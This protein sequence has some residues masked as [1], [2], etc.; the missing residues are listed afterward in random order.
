M[1]SGYH[2]YITIILGCL[3]HVLIVLG[4]CITK[5]LNDGPVGWTAAFAYFERYKLGHEKKKTQNCFTGGWTCQVG[6]VGQAIFKNIFYFL[7]LVAKMTLKTQKFWKKLTFFAEKFWENILT[8]FK[9]FQL[10]FLD[11]VQ[12]MADFTRFRKNQKKK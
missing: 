1:I 10:K 7:F 11:F 9:N 4:K 5:I 8:Y 2:Y 3:S 6:S 12:K